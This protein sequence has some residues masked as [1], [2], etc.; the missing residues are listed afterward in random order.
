[1][2]KAKADPGGT[3]E[4]RLIDPGRGTNFWRLIAQMRTRWPEEELLVFLAFDDEP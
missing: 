1:M 2:D 3:G 4:L